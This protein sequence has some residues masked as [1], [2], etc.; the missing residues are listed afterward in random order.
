MNNQESGI[1]NPG[2]IVKY[3]DVKD[4]INSVIKT[5][6]DIEAG[7]AEL[8]KSINDPSTSF[9]K[10]LSDSSKLTILDM[11]RKATLDAAKRFSAT[12]IDGGEE[13]IKELNSLVA[14]MEK[15]ESVVEENGKKEEEKEKEEKGEGEEKEK[16]EKKEGEEKEGEEKK[17]EG[18]NK[19][20]DFFEKMKKDPVG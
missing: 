20:E 3:E 9:F 11:Q 4:I 10:R 2:E 7:M 17:T 1:P 18:G 19:A 8:K 6:K 5:L 15:E 14:L 16:K 12:N 13:K